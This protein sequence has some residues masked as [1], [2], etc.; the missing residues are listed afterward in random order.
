MK[1][2]SAIRLCLMLAKWFSLCC[3][4]YDYVADFIRNT[5]IKGLPK[6][7]SGVS[8]GYDPLFLNDIVI[9]TTLIAFQSL[10]FIA[11]VFL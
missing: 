7:V 11:F 9:L 8:G 2:D 3:I 1:F 4:M 5:R 10:H 6:G